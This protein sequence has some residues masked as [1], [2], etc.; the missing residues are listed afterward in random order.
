VSS[1]KSER[2]INLTIALLAT[3]RF[4]TKDEIFRTIE[5]YEGNA[6]A[7]ERM[8]ERDKEDLRSLGISIEVGE[9]DPLFNDESGYRITPESYVLNLGE[10][11]GSDIA[12][13]S[14]ATD[15]W[16]DVAFSEWGLSARLKLASLGI[17]SDYQD[18]PAIAPHI[19]INNPNF[20]L[21]V[22]AIAESREASFEYLSLEMSVENRKINPYGISNR[23][24]AWYVVGLD[25]EKN[26]LR[27]FR[28]DRIVGEAKVAKVEST[29]EIPQDFN[30]AN[31]LDENLF[32]G[33]ETATLLIRKGKGS[34][35][36]SRSNSTIDKGE[37]DEC[38]ISFSN[39]DSFADLIL[40]H[41]DD[42]V[43]K[44]PLDLRKTVISRLE[45]L[46]DSHD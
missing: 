32:S 1:R 24:G 22:K 14:L 39:Q 42:V 38:S 41:G 18:I 25:I 28:L 31:F 20:S 16:R 6:E 12:L 30:V 44:K 9:L 3:K 27:T 43:V 7:K 37:F 2:L 45:Q 11:N 35:L 15:A 4:L 34:Q 23:F 26:S 8:F 5:G 46:V 10:L 36:R 19:P 17:D 29:Y 40:W 33:S 13:L 21:L